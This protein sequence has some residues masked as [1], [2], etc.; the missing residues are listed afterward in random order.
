MRFAFAPLTRGD[1]PL[2]HAWLQQPHVRAHYDD[3]LR[4]LAQVADHYGGVIRGEDATRAYIASCDRV[5]IGY[6]QSYRIADYPAYADALG[7]TD[8]AAGVDM[9][10]GDPAYV[11]RGLGAPLLAAFVA[12]VVTAA[13]CWIGPAVDNPRAIRAYERAGFEH[14]RTID[15]PGESQPEYLMRCSTRVT[16]GPT[17][18]R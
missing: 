14:V 12:N 5:R 2:L 7:V 3:G 15:V 9:L 8:D 6:L 4:T 16:G 17:A 11:H 1:L 13:T 10:I 18:C